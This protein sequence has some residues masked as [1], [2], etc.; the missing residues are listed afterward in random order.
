[1]LRCVYHEVM[2]DQTK[3]PAPLRLKRETFSGECQPDL[4]S[5]QEGPAHGAAQFADVSRSVDEGLA[6]GS[7]ERPVHLG[8]SVQQ[9]DHVAQGG[10]CFSAFGTDDR[11]RDQVDRRGDPVGDPVMQF[12]Q[13][14]AVLRTVRVRAQ[15]S[16]CIVLLRWIG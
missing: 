11:S 5:I 16:H 9:L 3:P 7:C 8:M 12:A 15:H 2:D 14:D 1:M 10:L 13:Q 6:L 4:H